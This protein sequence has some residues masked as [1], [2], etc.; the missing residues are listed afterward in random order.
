[1]GDTQDFEAAL[2]SLRAG[3][4]SALDSV[5]PA[6][7]AE[8]YRIAEACLAGER[9]DDTLQPTALIHEAYLRLLGGLARQ[10]CQLHE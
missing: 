6:L 10:A 7:Y 4:K 8:L 5:I 2:A 3:D 9:L 1:M